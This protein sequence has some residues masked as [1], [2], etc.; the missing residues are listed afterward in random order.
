[1]KKFML[2]L[3]LFIA[4]C[5]GRQKISISPIQ[6]MGTNELVC[7]CP[8]NTSC[9][10]PCP[11][12]SEIGNGEICS[13]EE[14][15]APIQPVQSGDIP[16]PILSVQ[17][18]PEDDDF[19]D[20]PPPILPSV[21]EPSEIIEEELFDHLGQPIGDANYIFMTREEEKKLRF[22]PTAKGRLEMGEMVPIWCLDYKERWWK[23]WV[24]WDV[25]FTFEIM[26]KN[27]AARDDIYFYAY[28]AWRSLK[29][30]G[31]KFKKYGKKHAQKKGYSEHYKTAI[32]IYGAHGNS[33]V[34]LWLWKKA[35]GYG[36]IPSY[37]ITP[38]GWKGKKELW[39]WRFVGVG[40]AVKFHKKHR[41]V[42]REVISKLEIAKNNNT[43]DHIDYVAGP[44]AIK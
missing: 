36:F 4:G 24:R 22:T 1:M 35:Y 28:Q 17:I 15:V 34:S 31:K 29:E 21:S 13:Q 8:K 2:L 40:P 30:Q 44:G 10:C 42:Y 37:Y 16:P 23:K 32:D 7:L 6:M 20:T 26:R 39:H 43:L 11:D 19:G 25:F 5:T 9:S 14:F 38:K 41:D 3:M 27:A 18:Q 12:G 33:D